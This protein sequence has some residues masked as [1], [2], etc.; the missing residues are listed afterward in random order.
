MQ[1]MIMTTH[2]L[3]PLHVVGKSHTYYLYHMHC[4]TVNSDQ[5]GHCWKWLQL[6]IL[7]KG[8]SYGEVS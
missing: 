6:S 8:L 4:N 1:K 7:M 5:D 2:V 3:M